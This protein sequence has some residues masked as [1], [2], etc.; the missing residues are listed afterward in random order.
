M[1]QDN[2]S[3]RAILAGLA[4]LPAFR[5]ARAQSAAPI[6]IGQ[7]LSLTGPFA[8]TASSIRS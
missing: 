7:T 2:W 4:S 5:L 8:Q 1:F 6:R 3:R